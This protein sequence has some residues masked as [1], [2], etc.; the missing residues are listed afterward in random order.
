MTTKAKPRDGDE[1]SDDDVA[2]IEADVDRVLEKV[3]DLL[4]DG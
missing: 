2:R 4:E 3:G 1:E